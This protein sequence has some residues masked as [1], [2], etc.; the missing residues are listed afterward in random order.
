MK[1]T[2]RLTEIDI[3]W[4]GALA[5]MCN[6]FPAPSRLEVLAELVQFV[7]LVSRAML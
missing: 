4:L 2:D 6:P 3:L 5:A 7:V 1:L